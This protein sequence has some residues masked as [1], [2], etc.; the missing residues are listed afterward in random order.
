MSSTSVSS[1]SSTLTE[2]RS[3][4]TMV[5]V[6][7]NLTRNVKSVTDANEATRYEL[8]ASITI[9]WR[10]TDKEI[11]VELQRDISSEEASG[12]IDYAIAGMANLLCITEEK[13]QNISYLQ[14]IQQLES[15]F[16]M[17]KRK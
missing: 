15:F 9:A 8:H 11:N 16:Y 3:T 2:E 12:R 5:D 4:R 6:I 13:L 10:S 1:P 17:N 14:N 7:K